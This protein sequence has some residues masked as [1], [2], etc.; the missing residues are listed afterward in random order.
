MLAAF[1]AATFIVRLAMRWIIA[2]R[3]P[4]QQVLTDRRCSSR[5]GVYLA[6]PFSHSAAML[7]A[8]SF[9]LGLGL[10]ASQPMVMSLLHTHAPPGRMGEA[11]GVRMSLVQVDGGRR[12]AGVRRAR[13]DVGLSPVFWSVGVFLAT[14]GWLTRARHDADADSRQSRR[15]A[16]SRSR[17]RLA[18]LGDLRR[19]DDGQYGW[20]PLRSK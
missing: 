14:G 5:R 18:E 20:P 19:D 6:F 7:M 1:A 17:E 4:E 9:C 2:A 8:L 16:G 12:A 11:A 13:R 10:G 15:G 3:P